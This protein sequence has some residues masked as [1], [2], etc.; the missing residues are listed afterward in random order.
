MANNISYH[1]IATD[2][3]TPVVAN[4]QKQTKKATKAIELM[5]LKMAKAGRKM[6][7]VGR[8]LTTSL[9]LPLA[10][11]GATA[12]KIA[13]D[14]EA[15]MNM[16]GAVAQANTK[17]IKQ[18]R[19]AALDLGATTQFTA[20]DVAN[21][22]KFL[23][24]AGKHT[25]DI[26]KMLPNVLQLAAAGQMDMSRAADIATNAMAAFG[27]KTSELAEVND[28]LVAVFTNSKINLEGLSSAMKFAGATAQSM[29]IPLK[30]TIALLG[31]A[32]QGGLQPGQMGRGFRVMVRD[33]VK[34]NKYLSRIMKGNKISLYD[35]QGHTNLGKFIVSL[36]K[37]GVTGKTMPY[38]FSSQAGTMASV[39]MQQSSI[40]EVLLKKEAK[41]AGLA[42]QVSLAQM[43]GLPGTTK[44]LTSAYEH[45]SIM[46]TT[47]AAPAL[48]NIYNLITKTM[49]ASVNSG[50][51]IRGLTAY[52]VGFGIVLGPVLMGLG[53]VVLFFAILQKMG[54]LALVIKGI[55]T[56]FRFLWGSILGPITLVLAA[57]TSLVLIYKFFAKL[58][59]Q[60][61]GM[62]SKMF[63]VGGEQPKLASH[64][65]GLDGSQF[66]MASKLMGINS[67]KHDPVAVQRATKHTVNSKLDVNIKDKGNNVAGVFG[68][69]DGIMNLFTGRNMAMA[70]AT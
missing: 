66:G 15:S 68:V 65:M 44:R 58:K 40:I 52:F 69:S 62:S 22:E 31:A 2:L 39:L 28:D 10:I 20:R 4:I 7:S 36:K 33:I 1:F 60:P 30:Q 47:T 9:T 29:N 3:Y 38:L 26:I 8:G 24:L 25:H 12:V 13:T 53:K 32:A 42:K 18:L 45:M 19:Q 56:A 34:P 59:N 54:T 48:T 5:S 41:A 21:A 23:G 17:Q 43:K 49:L 46:L 6:S 57:L 70:G 55:A 35:K 64:L 11:F 50:P 14:F 63:G 51:K 61:L 37:A 16:V 67:S 27:K